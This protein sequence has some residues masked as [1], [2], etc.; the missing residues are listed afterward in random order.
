M[1][2]ALSHSPC[3]LWSLEAVALCE[4]PG[5]FCHFGFAFG[6]LFLWYTHN[7]LFIFFESDLQLF[8]KEIFLDS[9]PFLLSSVF[10][11]DH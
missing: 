4:W 8:D 6:V 3:V 10:L 5:T 7:C 9:L 1:I 2:K 11:P